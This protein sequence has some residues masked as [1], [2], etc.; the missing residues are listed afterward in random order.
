M[1]QAEQEH[2]KEKIALITGGTSGLG[3][4]TTRALAAK[5]AH[6]V[7]VGR[8]E[9][10]CISTAEQI[11]AQTGNPEVEFIVGD[12]SEQAQVRR[13]ADTF[14][15]RYARL[16]VLVNNA[17]S[18]YLWRR[19]TSDGLEMTFALNH[20]AYFHLTNLLL[21][22]LIQSAPSRVVNVASGSHRGVQLDFHDLQAEG[23][24]RPMRAY[25]RSK[26]ANILF[27][28]ELDRRLPAAGVTSNAVHPG[29]VATNIGSDNGWIVKLF[30]PLVH[31]RSKSVAEGAETIIWLASSPEVEDVSG[32]YFYE[33]R[34]IQSAPA[35]YD[36]E[37]A[38]RLWKISANLTGLENTI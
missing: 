8:D 29:M 26:L 18:I 36:R 22:L 13:I 24:Y 30:L 23:G 14:R 31:W 20:L 21:D 1:G 10:K 2:V 25:G 5:G 6:A 11:Q 37:A 19:V 34:E 7:F 9:A 17:G 12:L 32:S 38:Q 3:K 33:K 35:S 16:D 4:E 15:L 28:Y 27:T